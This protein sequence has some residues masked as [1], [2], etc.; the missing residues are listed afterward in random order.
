MPNHNVP[1]LFSLNFQTHVYSN[2]NVIHVSLICLYLN[3]YKMLNFQKGHP[4]Y[5]LCH[6]HN[7]PSSRVFLR[8]WPL[9]S[10][11]RQSSVQGTRIQ[12][13]QTLHRFC[14]NAEK[15]ELI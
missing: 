2:G 6:P 14:L 5:I 4:R 9:W 3:H 12:D 10:Q 15:H 1:S 7:P 11:W 13:L 8:L